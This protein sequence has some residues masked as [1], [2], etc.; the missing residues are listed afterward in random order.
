MLKKNFSA[1]TEYS[2]TVFF[3]V[4]FQ[5]YAQNQSHIACL[6]NFSPSGVWREVRILFEVFRPKISAFAYQPDLGSPLHRLA[7]ETAGA[8]RALSLDFRAKGD[9]SFARCN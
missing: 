9:H 5:S 4:C 6:I 7:I 2:K 8:T 3:I 1:L